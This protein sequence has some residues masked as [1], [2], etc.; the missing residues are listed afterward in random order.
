MGIIA[1]VSIK[2]NLKN[3][4]IIKIDKRIGFSEFIKSISNKFNCKIISLGMLRDKSNE[5]I[6]FGQDDWDNLFVLANSQGQGQG[7]GQDN[8]QII[9]LICSPHPID[10]VNHIGEN[11]I[12]NPNVF[13]S[14]YASNSYVPTEAKTQ[15]ADLKSLKGVEYLIGMPDLHQGKYPVGS[16]VITSCETL[17]DNT[18][19]NIST[20]LYEKRY[21]IYPELVG[22]DIGCGMSLIKTSIKTSK[23]SSKQLEKIAN[24]MEIGKFNLTTQ[25]EIDEHFNKFYSNDISIGSGQ[26]KSK[27][28]D[29]TWFDYY[30]SSNL[31]NLSNSTNP[32]NPIVSQSLTVSI[33]KIK[34]L[35]TK[36]IDSMGTIGLGNHFVELLQFDKAKSNELIGKYSIDQDHYY[37]LVHSGSRGLGE[38][39]LQLYMNKQIDLSQY[40]ILHDYA[41]DWAIHNRFA[42]GKQFATFI[43]TELE[44]LVDLTHNWV[45]QL[46]MGTKTYYIHRKGAA[47]AY[48]LP[49]VIPGS[50]G[51]RTWLVEPN[52]LTQSL[53]TGY[54]VSHGAGRKVSRLKA[55]TGMRAKTEKDR[56]ICCQGD[57]DISNIVI[58]E[59]T[60]LF[61][62]EAPFAYKDIQAVIDDL[63][64]FKLAYPICSFVPVITFK[65]KK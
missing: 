64:H 55:Q 34:Y 48:D 53:Q 8:Q 47:P 49:I 54:S 41:V 40:K 52:K 39:I 9:K 29:D 14:I 19:E 45:E 13:F 26:I 44:Y 38:E 25:C 15:L 7:Q 22:T 21:P 62:E 1:E 50:R 23:Y 51:T 56:E 57:H 43:N 32:A 3:K 4:K 24:K 46:C 31:T 28:I 36:Y 30:L 16:V 5:A 10:W 18:D 2:E 42:I 35:R 20:N 61:Y 6:S 11:S 65:C 33:N 58:C 63:E 12:P 59:D 37:I 60:N 27:P 17:S